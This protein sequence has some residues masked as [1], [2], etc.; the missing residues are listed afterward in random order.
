MENGQLKYYGEYNISPERQNIDD[1]ELHYARRNKLYRQCGLP[2]IAFRGAEMLEVGPGSGYNTLAYFHWGCEHID[3]IEA[4]PQ[5]IKDMEMLFAEKKI[6]QDKYEV[7][8]CLIENYNTNKRYDIIVAEGFMPDIDNQ[9]EVVDK[10]KELTNEKG[11]IVI[12]C[13][14]KV[15]FF[16][17]SM[18]RLVGVILTR[19][20]PSYEEKLK[21]LIDLFKPQL[22]KLRGM[23]K[24]P[25]DWVKDIILNPVINNGIELGLGQAIHYFQE[26]FEILGTSP[27]MFTD[28]SWSKDI[29]YDYK[30]DYLEQFDRKRLSLLMA[31]MPEVILPSD[32]ARFLV[33]CFEDIKDAEA[34]YENT[35]DMKNISDIVGIMESIENL[36]RQYFADDFMSVFYEIKDVL[37]SLQKGEN[38]DMGNYP[39]F[40]KAFGR[41]Q[42]YISFVRK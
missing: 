40:F 32:D 1:I 7:F 20:I 2:E 31:N 14:D 18:K 29:W 13:V 41:T 3:L 38:V 26:D 33:K 6:S 30:K 4:N 17:E 5:G 27:Q 23:S 24:L 22:A 37:R 10:L 25:E 21:F 19:Q 28:Y 39:N 36:L 34:E 11:V 42:Q 16:I 35:L 8:D 12:T 15:D 9:K